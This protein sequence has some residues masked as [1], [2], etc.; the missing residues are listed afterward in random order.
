MT[1]LNWCHRKNLPCLYYRL[2]SL[3]WA[4]EFT[5]Y[6]NLSVWFETWWKYAWGASFPPLC[7]LWG[8]NLLSRWQV[9]ERK[10]LH[11]LFFLFGF[12][13]IIWVLQPR[14]VWETHAWGTWGEDFE[15]YCF[16]F[17]SVTKRQKF[18]FTMWSSL[19]R[20]KVGK[21]NMNF[22]LAMHF[23]KDMERT[24]RFHFWQIWIQKIIFGNKPLVDSKTIT[25]EHCRYGWRPC[26][27]G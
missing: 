1:P 3:F 12:W 13:I 7:P 9:V 2:L 5:L 4:K 17:S 16:S 23:T 21:K 18:E 6:P 22:L 11:H 24:V 26:K 20:P 14:E 19:S 15:F 10:F 25:W 8:C 27:R